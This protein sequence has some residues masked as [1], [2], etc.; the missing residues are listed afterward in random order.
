MRQ[1]KHLIKYLMHISEK[2]NSIH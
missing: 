2:E 1:I